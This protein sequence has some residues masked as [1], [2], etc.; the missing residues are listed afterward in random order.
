[1]KN[2]SAEV[3]ARQAEFVMHFLEASVVRLTIIS[4]RWKALS[5]I[6][7]FR[8]DIETKFGREKSL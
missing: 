7:N 5:E 1:M 3:V 2:K 8:V 6:Y 4:M